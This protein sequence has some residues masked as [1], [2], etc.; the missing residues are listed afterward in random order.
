MS[1]G[2]PVEPFTLIFDLVAKIDGT[3]RKG[4]KTYTA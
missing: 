2:K 3:Y 4:V 1:T